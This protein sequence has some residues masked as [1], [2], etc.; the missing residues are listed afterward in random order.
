MDMDTPTLG[1]ILMGLSIVLGGTLVALLIY[2]VSIPHAPYILVMLMVLL[3]LCA[4]LVIVRSLD[5]A[6]QKTSLPRP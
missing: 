4:A 2:G 1:I 5:A 3:V 6:R